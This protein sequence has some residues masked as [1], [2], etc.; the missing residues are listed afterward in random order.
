MLDGIAAVTGIPTEFPGY[1]KGTRALELPDSQVASYFLTAFGRPQRVQTCSC[2][3]QEEPS[4]VQALHLNNGDTINARLRASGGRVDGW[5]S[6]RL[7]DEEVL[8][9]VTLAALARL[10]TEGE[11]ARILPILAEAPLP[12]EAGGAAELS[13]RRQVIE[14]LLW[15]TLTSKEFLFNH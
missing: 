13:A 14:D 3:R 4:L 15:A 12:A 8:K 1:P 6:D 9:Q 7:P 10:P 2:E 11:R 5:L